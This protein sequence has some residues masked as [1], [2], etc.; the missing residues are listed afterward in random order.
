VI[1]ISLFQLRHHQV[2]P[3]EI[4]NLPNAPKSNQNVHLR[5]CTNDHVLNAA[6]AHCRVRDNPIFGRE[7]VDN[8]SGYRNDVVE[9][10]STGTWPC[11]GLSEKH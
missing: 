2:K 1:R 3:L 10:F 11:T 6:A 8:W 7:V 9:A 4:D 5:E